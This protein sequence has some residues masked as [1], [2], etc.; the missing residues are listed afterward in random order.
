MDF[1]GSAHPHRSEPGRTQAAGQIKNGAQ[2]PQN[3]VVMKKT[4]NDP[5]V[6]KFIANR[7]PAEAGLIISK[8]RLASPPLIAHG[9]F[10]LLY[11]RESSDCKLQY[12]PH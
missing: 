5:N 11:G 12:R 8:C 7:K 4:S 3:V 2:K 9:F 10:L 6:A 1:R